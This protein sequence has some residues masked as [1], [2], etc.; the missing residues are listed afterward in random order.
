M[1]RNKSKATIFFE[2]NYSDLRDKRIDVNYY[3]KTRLRDLY[4]KRENKTYLTGQPTI[5]KYNAES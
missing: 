5:P 1:A 2:R 3:P 4:I